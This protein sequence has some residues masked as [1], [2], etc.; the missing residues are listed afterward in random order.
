MCGHEVAPIGDWAVTTDTV[1]I[2]RDEWDRLR[3]SAEELEDLRA[4]LAAQ[5]AV[6][7][8]AEETLPAAVANRL[9]DRGESPLR[10]WREYRDLSPAAL[11]ERSGL[12]EAQIADIEREGAAVDAPLQSYLRLAEALGVDIDDLV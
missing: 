6:A 9:M 1:T 3:R 2:T 5:R 7:T 10:V 8:G 4:G 12:S 11:A